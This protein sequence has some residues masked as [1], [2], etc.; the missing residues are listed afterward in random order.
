MNQICSMNLHGFFSMLKSCHRQ[1][2]VLPQHHRF[3]NL[4]LDDVDDGWH[5]EL[6]GRVPEK[7][8][9]FRILKL[10]SDWQLPVLFALVHPV[11]MTDRV[12]SI[13]PF[14][15]DM[16]HEM[17]IQ[18]FRSI[19]FSRLQIHSWDSK[20]FDLYKGW[21]HNR[22]GVIWRCCCMGSMSDLPKEGLFYQVIQFWSDS[23]LPATDPLHKMSSS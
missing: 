6:F 8:W 5:M 11:H 7:S 23:F 1:V 10:A 15:H 22:K 4:A 14:H 19:R 13:I 9:V 12:R 21:P 18:I 2:V 3:G 20:P 17:I 16:M